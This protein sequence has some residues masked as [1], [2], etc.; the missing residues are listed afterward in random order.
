MTLKRLGT[1]RAPTIGVNATG[2]GG[3][4]EGGAMLTPP[5]L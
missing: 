3:R 2:D 1:G 5:N 4:G